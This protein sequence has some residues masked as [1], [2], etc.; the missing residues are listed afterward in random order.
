V[1]TVQIVATCSK[2]NSPLAKAALISGR[3]SSFT[4]PERHGSLKSWLAR[5]RPAHLA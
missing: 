4:G 1:A 3:L 5:E 2:E